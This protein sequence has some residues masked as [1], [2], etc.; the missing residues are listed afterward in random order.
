MNLILRQ[1]DDLEPDVAQA[2]QHSDFARALRWN[3]STRRFAF[4][5]WG[6][7]QLPHT[8]LFVVPRAWP[9]AP[10]AT[11]AASMLLVLGIL[12]QYSNEPNQKSVDEEPVLLTVGAG[13]QTIAAW[14]AGLALLADHHAHGDLWLTERQRHI[15]Q[16][17][18]V[19]WSR[20]ERQGHPI[21]DTNGTR[22]LRFIRQRTHVYPHHPFA[23]LHQTVLSEVQE[24]LGQPPRLPVS[25]RL[26]PSEQQWALQNASGRLFADRPRTLARHIQTWL[27]RRTRGGSDSKP[28]AG[29]VVLRPAMVWERMLGVA[30]GHNRERSTPIRGEYAYTSGPC[31]PGMNLRPDLWV[32][33][34]GQRLCID[35]KDYQ[36]E[37]LP[38]SHDIVK[39]A[40][41]RLARLHDD[42]PTHN[43][44]VIPSQQ[45]GVMRIA[46][47]TASD[48][49]DGWFTIGVMGASMVEVAQ[50]YLRR[51]TDERLLDALLAHNTIQQPV[52]S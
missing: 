31:K 17:G 42:I 39:Q 25:Q 48:D 21:T 11:P 13:T 14:E 19:H 30:L 33:R 44:F 4:A 20:T 10:T 2:I 45:P 34:D 32:E 1:G 28:V 8:L 26:T 50:A 22:F 36:A 29:M 16:P 49:P 51:C 46:Q 35:A 15:D 27:R 41:Y 7:V 23:R 47:H 52:A 5:G 43:L 24:L 9:H 40:A 18:Q 38:P 37:K 12:S 3:G 6:I